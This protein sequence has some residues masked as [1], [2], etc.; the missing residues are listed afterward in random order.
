M[1]ARVVPVACLP[2]APQSDRSFRFVLRKPQRLELWP[3]NHCAPRGARTALASTPNRSTGR[4]SSAIRM[5][6]APS[7]ASSAC[8]ASI[9]THI[10]RAIRGGGRRYLAGGVGPSGSGPLPNAGAAQPGLSAVRTR[11]RRS[12]GRCRSCSP[13]F[14]ACRR[15]RTTG[16]RPGTARTTRRGTGSRARRTE[17]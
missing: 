17:G 15:S 1:T 3:S 11:Y 8:S 4:S 13:T 2:N 16:P 6:C 14:S 9:R 5:R 7:S 12:A 10:S